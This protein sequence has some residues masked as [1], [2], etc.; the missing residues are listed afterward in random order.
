LI[1]PGQGACLLADMR[2]PDELAAAIRAALGGGGA[3][4]AGV[5][6]AAQ[7][8]AVGWGEAA[9]ATELGKLVQPHV[10]GKKLQLQLGRGET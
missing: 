10:A 8:L 7:R 9:Y 6:E 3:S 5:G 4:L 1:Q 2:N